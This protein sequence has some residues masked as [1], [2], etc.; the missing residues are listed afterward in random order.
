MRRGT[1]GLSAMV[2]AVEEAPGSE[3]IVGFRGK[4]ADRIKL[5]WWDGQ[6]F[7]LFYKILERG[8]FPWQTAKVGVAHLTQAQLSMLVEGTDRR[9]PAWISAPTE[10]PQ[11]SAFD[12]HRTVRSNPDA[13][14]SHV[15]KAVRKSLSTQ[16]IL[17]LASVLEV[18]PLTCR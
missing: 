15:F 5:L 3:A 18:A 6:R 14:G 1:D 13:D 8:Y 11:H 4:R 16:E 17:R 7:C 9:L 2:E 12:W 10:V